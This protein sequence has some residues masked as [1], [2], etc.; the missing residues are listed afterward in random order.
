MRIAV[1][2]GQKPWNREVTWRSSN[3]CSV[4][5]TS[6]TAGTWSVEPHFEMCLALIVQW[7]GTMTDIDDQRR[8]AELLERLVRERTADL[9]RSNCHLQ[10]FAAVASHDLQEP[11]RKIQAFGD[12]LRTSARRLLGKQ[13]KEYLERIL[14]SAARMRTL[15]NDLLAFSRITTE[16]HAFVLVD[17]AAVA[18]EVVSDLEE[19][20]QADQRH[21]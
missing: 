16:W 21:C 18:Y 3:G 8:Q 13:G 5:R 11:L 10:E 9:E 12:R 19:L 4:P 7:V 20:I 14:K 1:L 17:L 15:I 6:P 2:N